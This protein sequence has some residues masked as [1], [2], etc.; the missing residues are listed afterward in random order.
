LA[1]TNYCCIKR[2]WKTQDLCGFL[3]TQC[4]YQEGSY[5]LPYTKDVLDEVVGHEVYSFLDGFSGYHQI[6]IA[7]ENKYKIAFIID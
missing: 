7:L 3:M 1:I 6:M 2:E 5:P 4:Y